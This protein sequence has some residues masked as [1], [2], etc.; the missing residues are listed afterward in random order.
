MEWRSARAALSLSS[1]LPLLP[2][3][4]P[5]QVGLVCSWK[6]LRAGTYTE[7]AYLLCEIIAL[8]RVRLAR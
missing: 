8:D 5:P 6:R 2:S 4:P 3:P 1:R 7:F